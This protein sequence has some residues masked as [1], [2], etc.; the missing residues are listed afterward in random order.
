MKI[1]AKDLDKALAGLPLYVA[2][3]DDEIAVY[4]V[5]LHLFLPPKSFYLNFNMMYR[6]I[7]FV[8]GLIR[9]GHSAR[10]STLSA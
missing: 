8:R 9:L 2:K 6:S 1:I 3:Y 5:R 10:Y 7:D 4:R